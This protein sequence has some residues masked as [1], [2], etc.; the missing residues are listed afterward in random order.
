MAM[1]KVSVPTCSSDGAFAGRDVFGARR[2]VNQGKTN[3]MTA[4]YLKS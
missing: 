1:G 3:C 4:G 2:A